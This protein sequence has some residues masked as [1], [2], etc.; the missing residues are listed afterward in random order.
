M[1]INNSGYM[2]QYAASGTKQHHISRD[3]GGR[4]RA[5]SLVLFCS[6]SLYNNMKYKK[7]K[8]KALDRIFVPSAVLH[9]PS[10]PEAR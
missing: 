9:Q 4:G 1:V 8:D 10:P 7:L 6:H 2:C 5:G 3:Q